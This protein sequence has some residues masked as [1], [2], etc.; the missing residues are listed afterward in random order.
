MSSTQMSTFRT[1]EVEE[2]VLAGLGF[3]PDRLARVVASAQADV[4]AGL[5]D[6]VSL[7]V[8]RRGEVALSFSTGYAERATG[9]E[10]K[11]NTVFGTQSVGKQFIHALVLSYV[12]RGLLALHEPVAAIL[13]GFGA[14]GKHR[15]TLAHLLTHTSG[16][17]SDIPPLPLNELGTQSVLAAYAMGS[18]IESKPG[19]RVRYSITCASAIMAELLLTVDGHTRSLTQFLNDELF[20]PLGMIDTS[21]GVRP[22]LLDRLAPVTASFTGTGLFPASAIDRIAGMLMTPGNEMASGGYV[23]TA[24]DLSRFAEMLARGGELDGTRLLS[25]AMLEVATR[26]HTGEMS[27][28]LFDYT[29]TD[30]NWEPF[31]AYL[32]LGFFLRGEKITPGF[33][34]TLASPRTFGGFGA[35]STCFWVDPDRELTFSLLTTGLMEESR[36]IE[37]S[38]RLGDLVISSI[39]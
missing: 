35:G 18:L 26:N 8:L 16:L 32:G 2:S 33:I 6:G 31:P 29:I 39:V 30:R 11:E 12:E 38:R 1:T 21:M 25:P 7:R 36:H 3:D 5:C 17:M 19:E 23:T 13:P 20:A 14:R 22:D 15:I 34:G 4:E 28:N 37:R 10:L 24:F 27:N 9:R